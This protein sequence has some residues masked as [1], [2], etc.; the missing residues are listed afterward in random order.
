MSELKRSDWWNKHVKDRFDEFNNWLGDHDQI[1]KAWCR[2]YIASQGYKSIVDIG[3]GAASEYYGYKH[4]QYDI[5]YTGLD[6]CKHLIEFNQGKGIKMV[7][8]NLEDPLPLL[9]NSYEVVYCRGVLEHLT[10]YKIAIN[11]FIRSA[12]KEVVIGWFI[13]PGNEEDQINY[14]EEEG[15][16]HNKYNKQKIEELLKNN[17]KVKSF[18]WHEINDQENVLLIKLV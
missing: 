18:N 1:T 6:S 14:W 3:S 16:Y 15:L 4:D 2:K 9:D 5:D 12:E 8:G 11:E 13:K 7:E 17:T 10:N